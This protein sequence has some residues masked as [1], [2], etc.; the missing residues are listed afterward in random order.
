MLAAVIQQY[1]VKDPTNSSHLI[2]A[3]L[4]KRKKSTKIFN[5]CR[6]LNSSDVD[7]LGSSSSESDYDDEL[8]PAHLAKKQRQQLQFKLQNTWPKAVQILQAAS[9]QNA[10]QLHPTVGGAGETLR[11]QCG[12][13]KELATAVLKYINT[14]TDLKLWW[15]TQP[16]ITVAT[17]NWIL[18]A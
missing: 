18:R 9:W 11:L 7:D 13:F 4:Y 14:A 12:C 16:L 8:E 2:D 1:F 10:E 3:K 15:V 5:E 6:Y 17:H